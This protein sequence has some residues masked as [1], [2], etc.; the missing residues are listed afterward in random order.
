MRS[1]IP[2]AALLAVL[3]YSPLL[4]SQTISAQIQ[5][6]VT[7][8]QGAVVPL[9]TVAAVNEKTGQTYRVQSNSTGNYSLT[10][11]L[12]GEYR[13]MVEATGFKQAIVPAIVLTSGQSARADVTLLV[14][15][16]SEQITVTDR[17]AAVD[18][19]TN[20]LES[21]VE[22]RKIVD[23]PIGNRNVLNLAILSAAVTSVSTTNDPSFGQQTISINGARSYSTNIQ[24]D[25]A[26]MYYGHRGQGLIQPPPDAVQELRIVT[27]GV[28][29]E[30]GR[31]TGSI[32]AVTKSGTNDF[33]G[34]LWNFLRNDALN[35][36]TFFAA[37]VPKLRYNQFGGTLGGPIRRNKTFFF[38]S[39]QGLEQRADEVASS[40]FPPNERERQGDLSQTPGNR[41][42]DP[43]TN[44]PF[45]GAQIPVSRFD[46]V[47]V[48]LLER[49]PL[50]NRPDG[51]YVTQRSVPTSSK[52]ILAR[53]DHDFSPNDR[54][55]FRYFID[56]PSSTSYLSGGNIDTYSP[57]ADTNRTQVFTLS[58]LHVFSPSL[59]GSFRFSH[60]RFLYSTAN[61]D[62]TTLADL[63]A[64]FITG[65][66]PGGLPFITVPG[67]VN[68]YSVREGIRF[69]PL[70]EGGGDFTWQLGRHE[71][72]FGGFSQRVRFNIKNQ[73]RANGDF[74]FSGDFTR[75]PLSDFLLGQP[76]ELWQEA[77]RDNDASYLQAGFFVQDRW[78]ATRKLTLT[79]GLRY[80]GYSPWRAVDGQ[81]GALVPGHQSVT[82]PTAPPGLL[83]QDDPDFPLQADLNNFGPRIGFAWD[84][85]GNGRTS[86][87]GG[88][89]VSFDPLIGQVATQNVPPF[90]SD[91]RTRNV[92][93]L[94]DP[95]RFVEVP[96]GQP[97]D[98]ENPVFPAAITL[99]N[100]FNG[101]LRTPYLQN[102]NFTLEQ[103]IAGGFVVQTS[104]VG[105]LGRKIAINSQQNP[106][107][108]IPGRS[109]S[110]NTDSRR[111][112]APTYTSIASY[113]TDGISSYHGLQIGVNKRF[114]QGYTFGLSYAWAKAIDEAS[115]SNVADNW[116]PQDPYNRRGSRGLSDFDVRNRLVMNGVWQMSFFNGT[117]G[118]AR[119]AFGGW[120]LS[121][122]LLLSDGTPFTVT[123]GR[124]N[125][126]RGVNLDRPNLLGNPSLSGDRSRADKLRQYFDTSMFVQNGVGEFGNAGRNILI[127]PGTVRLDTSLS[128]RFRAFGESRFLEFRWDVLSALNTPNFGNP[129]ANLNAAANFGRITSASG[130][131][132]MQLALRFEF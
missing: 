61:D 97:L 52:S 29:A 92:G 91:L 124:D 88:Y 122:I 68:A 75:N 51:S 26:S 35:A 70:F 46:P 90:N 15:S 54:T 30:Y 78:R 24:L 37:T 123:S 65:G 48:K 128:K 113:S 36:R 41:P 94:S 67:R 108:Y 77:F 98:R 5:G 76:V 43:L 99:T 42:V 39:Y 4:N 114:G 60:T 47:A 45:P 86:I 11:L 79:L 58:H 62:R 66:G 49:I 109:T 20:S 105:T 100:S 69:S 2:G 131:R 93:P 81:L 72:K 89:G 82:F 40:A 85:F 56:D 34:S 18:T 1:G 19:T 23:L 33:H 125:S 31:G 25:G 13:V 12:P 87:R 27:S 55:S 16:V 103:A 21:T 14:G 57:S 96:F 74:S 120:Q 119:T 80:E 107:I 110:A 111:I 84:V 101:E 130:N 116:R 118:W 106:A 10:G 7:D 83:Y 126:L 132:T 9:A 64:K 117:S 102:L 112:Y 38:A 121:G 129:G 127:G 104:Y 95:Q 73:G 71:V 22:T 17:V 59:L 44:Q 8:E 115:T 32:I 6:N 63:G 28:T 3:A 50:P 53:L